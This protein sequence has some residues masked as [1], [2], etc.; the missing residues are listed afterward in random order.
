MLL[1]PDRTDKTEPFAV[2]HQVPGRIRLRL[3]ALRK[4]ADLD[5]RVVR[6]LQDIDGVYAVRSNPACASLVIHY[7]GAS[8][9]G[10]ETLLAALRPII[11][12]SPNPARPQLRPEK[13]M[14]R[15][16]RAHDKATRTPLADCPICRLK[17]TAARWI[18]SDVWRCWRDHWTQRLRT[19]LAASFA[20]LGGA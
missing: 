2:C 20:L 18:L 12:P 9:P 8:A 1:F 5:E 3:P 4:H 15:T 11:K 19:R 6:A 13:Q 7:R 16:N 14:S 10:Q 17:L